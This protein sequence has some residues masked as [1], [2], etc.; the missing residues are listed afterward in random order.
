MKSVRIAEKFL[1]PLTI[2]TKTPDISL[3]PPKKAKIPDVLRLQKKKFQMSDSHS[4]ID[5]I[6]DKCFPTNSKQLRHT[7]HLLAALRCNQ[8]LDVCFPLMNWQNTRRL[9]PTL[10]N[11]LCPPQ[12]RTLCNLKCTSN[13][14]SHNSGILCPSPHLP[15]HHIDF[16]FSAVSLC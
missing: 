2:L 15:P 9:I 4:W 5:L 16:A 10:C 7:R 14:N 12:D 13:F 6:P 3:F 1:G 11:S 8:I